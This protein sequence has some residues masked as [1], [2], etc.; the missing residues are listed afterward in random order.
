ME[1][2]EKVTG[3]RNVPPLAAGAVAVAGV[4]GEGVAKACGGDDST[5]VRLLGLPLGERPAWLPWKASPAPAATTSAAA[6]EAT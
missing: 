3:T 5:A 1:T 6:A 2:M 4:V